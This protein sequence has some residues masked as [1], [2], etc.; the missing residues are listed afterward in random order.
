MSANDQLVHVGA[1]LAERDL[2]MLVARPSRMSDFAVGRLQHNA[3]RSGTLVGT[4]RADG[5]GL[6]MFLSE[7]PA[8]ELSVDGRTMRAP[9][10]RAGQFQLHNLNLEVTAYLKSPL[11]AIYFHIPRSVL[12]SVAQENSISAIETLDVRPGV[13]ALDGVVRDL[14]ISLLPSL[15]RI[16]NASR[17][18]MDHVGMALLAHLAQTYG[19]VARA[20]RDPGHD[21][22]ALQE[23]RVEEMIIAR[24][25]GTV[26]LNELAC[27]CSL[28]RMEFV[29]A[30]QKTKGRAP[31]R[32]LLEQRVARACALLRIR[33]VPLSD[34]AVLSGFADMHH[35]NEIFARA[36]GFSPDGWRRVHRS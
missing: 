33:R 3:R 34:I 25:D 27:E 19:H 13:S 23:R 4:P 32:W 31:H 30:F 20:S 15:Q 29:G 24:L 17:L 2:P 8:F 26:S 35:F 11:D 9:L 10:A 1:M 22:T 36:T 14:C 18:F 16:E 12:N 28:S 6:T 7:F 5:F 21:L